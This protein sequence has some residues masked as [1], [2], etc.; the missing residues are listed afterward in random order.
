MKSNAVRVTV[1]KQVI[2]LNSRPKHRAVKAVQN[3]LTD[4]VLSKMEITKEMIDSPES[5]DGAV[6]TAMTTDPEMMSQINELETTLLTDQT[7]MLAS[8]L[9]HSELRA[10]IDEAYEDEYRELYEKSV[11]VLGGDANSFFCIYEQNTSSEAPR[12]RRKAK[13]RNS[14]T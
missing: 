10:I 5:I 1:G 2:E 4:F 12:K 3:V 7:I 6:Q 8:G 9:T 11:E 14:G 13:S